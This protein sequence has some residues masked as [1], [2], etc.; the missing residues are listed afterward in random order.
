M[1][2][3]DTVGLELLVTSVSVD[4]GSEKWWRILNVLPKAKE[5]TL[6]DSAD[7]I[8]KPVLLGIL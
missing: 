5:V 4:R 1:A 2:C 6:V 3:G 7:F 8:E